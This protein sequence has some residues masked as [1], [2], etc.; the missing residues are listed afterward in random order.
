MPKVNELREVKTLGYWSAL[1]GVEV[2]DIQYGIE[3]YVVCLANAW[4]G[5]ASA[6]R[7]KVNYAGNRSFI[8]VHNTRLYMDECIRA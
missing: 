4:N 5:K 1:G 8:R 6:H 7:V 2:K 3:D